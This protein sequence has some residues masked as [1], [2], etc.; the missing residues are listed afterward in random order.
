MFKANNYLI[1]IVETEAYLEDAETVFTEG[2]RTKL[3]DF[4]AA[5]PDLGS[6]IPGTNG[7]RRLEWPAREFN[8]R[9]VVRVVYY[10]RDLNMPVFLL[11]VFTRKGRIA[12][13]DAEKSVWR[14]LVDALV[15]QYGVKWQGI[16][17][18][19]RDAG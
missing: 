19:S 10:F 16:I 11:A 12:P 8:R 15:D 13:T 7:V 3:A 18:L 17:R 1:S 6:I 9:G 4:L 2:E 14:D 5:N